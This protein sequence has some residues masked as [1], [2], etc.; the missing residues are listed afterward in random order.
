MARGDRS[1]DVNVKRL[2]GKL[3]KIA[4]TGL[5]IKTQPGTGYRLELAEEREPIA[6][7]V[8]AL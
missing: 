8:T 3:A 1:V 4:G 6:N 5:K 7:A 2:R